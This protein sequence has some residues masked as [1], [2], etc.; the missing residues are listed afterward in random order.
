MCGINGIFNYRGSVIPD[1]LPL[2]EKM[3]QAIAHR[4]PDD[5]GVWADHANGIYF[6]HRRL[7]ILDLSEKGHQPM[8]SPRGSTIVFNGEIYNFKELRNTFRDQPFISETDT[9]VLLA[10]YDRDGDGCLQPL[11]GM[12]SFAIWDEAKRRLFLARDRL[13]KK[14]LYYTTLG[15]VFAFSSEIKA[16]L[17]LPWIRPLLDEEALY[18]F[19]TFNSLMQPW[20]MFQ[21]IHKL[22]PG[23]HMSVTKDGI[24]FCE[25][26]WEVAYTNLDGRKEA[27]LREV[28]IR[29]L[30]RAVEMRMVSDVPVGAFLSGGVDSS[31]IVALMSQMSNS[32]VTTYSVGFEGAADYDEREYAQK[33]AKRFCTDHHEKIVRP[34]DLLDFL[35]RVV[36]IYDEPLADA[37][38]IP[39]YFIA[40]MARANKTLVVLTGDGADEL[41]CGY[42]SWLKYARLYPYYKLYSRV[43]RP[44][45]SAAARLY[46]AVDSSSPTYEMLARAVNNEE[47]F[48]GGAGGF[49]EATKRS[50]LS[51]EYARRMARTDSY[52]VVQ[53]YQEQFKRIPKNGRHMSYVDWM[54]FMGLKNMIP[55]L[56]L[57]RADRLG[58]ANSIELRTPF[59][60]YQLVNF[61]LSVP[62]A[63]KTKQ[64]E[65]KYI[66]KKALES[67]LPRETLYRK[68]QGFC[69]PLEEWT[70]AVIVNYV[71]SNL[72]SFCRDTGLFNESA[73]RQQIRHTRRGGS[74]YIFTLWNIYFLIAWF[75]KW[76]L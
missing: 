76:M 41:F 48:W 24:S 29:E 30:R 17:T 50:F 70:G 54:A 34:N 13:G 62:G 60:D 2:L 59:L 1:G 12:F 28:L 21:G 52:V 73:L 7:S 31:A 38:S 61:A 46:G 22:P 40:E 64:G 44:V 35:P 47:F 69:V 66:L 14:P 27:D 57:Y 15:G 45:K 20:T 72:K 56:Y 16:L 36:D 23:Y 18:H 6:G 33:I 32:R 43:P 65:P 51:D 37:T 3:N 67:L 26:Y 8:I 68:K 5:S 55:N 49:K 71:E 19:L 58:M 63:F 9:E 4:G 39:I 11:N 25:P 74:D 42:R 75:K 10:L 53:A